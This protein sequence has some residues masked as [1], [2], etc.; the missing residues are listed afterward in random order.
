MIRRALLSTLALS[1]AT[2]GVTVAATPAQAV[3]CQPIYTCV[4]HFY[5]NAAHTTLVGQKGFHCGAIPFQWG[6]ATQY[7]TY[8]I[9]DCA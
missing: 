9:T 7:T 4:S 5:N 8:T 2:I 3:Y 6:Q 1:A